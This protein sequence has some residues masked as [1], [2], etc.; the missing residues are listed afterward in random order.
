MTSVSPKPARATRHVRLDW[1][2]TSADDLKITL[3][4]LVGAA[5]SHTDII[6]DYLRD[7]DATIEY[8]ST[9]AGHRT[10]IKHLQSA[11]RRLQSIANRATPVKERA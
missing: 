7:I 6:D 1:I 11:R 2:S 10:R 3:R 8:C 5:R 4:N 9:L